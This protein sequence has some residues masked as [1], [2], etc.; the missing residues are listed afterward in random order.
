MEEGAFSWGT[1]GA[2]MIPDKTVDARFDELKQ[3]LERNYLEIRDTKLEVLKLLHE[4]RGKLDSI[5]SMLEASVLKYRRDDFD[6]NSVTSFVTLDELGIELADRPDEGE[7]TE[8][9]AVRV[10]STGLTAPPPERVEESW[11]EIDDETVVSKVIDN[12]DEYLKEN[13]PIMNSHLKLREIIPSSY[14]LSKKAKK[15]LK[16]RVADE[17]LDISLHKLDR[18]RGF[19]YKPSSWDDSLTPDEIYDRTLRNKE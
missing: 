14:T 15:L 19:Y 8:E 18:I 9:V 5:P 7:E 10:V 6:E 17:A 13:G 11:D 12:L 2:G 3:L 1:L 16:E 4:I